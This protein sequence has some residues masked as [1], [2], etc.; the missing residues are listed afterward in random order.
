M[1]TSVSDPPGAVAPPR[2]RWTRPRLAS[3]VRSRRMVSRDTSSSWAMDST[4]TEP[5]RSTV[6]WS[7]RSLSSLTRYLPPAPPA[8][9]LTGRA[10]HRSFGRDLRRGQPEVDAAAL[11]VSPD[12]PVHHQATDRQA[13]VEPDLL[14]AVPDAHVR[15]VPQDVQDDQHGRDQQRAPDADRRDPQQLAAAVPGP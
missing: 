2:V 14:G 10:V 12:R 8:A 15:V 11:T 6:S 13:D 1:S 5:S 4:S 9:R 7:L 3:A